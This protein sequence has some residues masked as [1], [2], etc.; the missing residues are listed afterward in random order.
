MDSEIVGSLIGWLIMCALCALVG[1]KRSIGYGWTFVLCL[2]VS[3][4][5]GM[6]IALCSKKKDTNFTEINNNIENQ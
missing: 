1:K 2:F 6:I 3:P 4:L 5:I